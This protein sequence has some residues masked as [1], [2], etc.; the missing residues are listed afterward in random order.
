MYMDDEEKLKEYVLSQDGIIYQGS[1]KF[2]VPIPWNFG[3]VP[4]MNAIQFN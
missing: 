4:N 2:P 3:Q 1:H